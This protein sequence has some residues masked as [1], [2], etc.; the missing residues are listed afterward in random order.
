MPHNKH[1][2]KNTIISSYSIQ[3]TELNAYMPKT[4]QIT[5]YI[6]TSNYSIPT[7]ELNSYIPCNRHF[8]TNTITSDYSIQ[9]TGL[10]MATAVSLAQPFYLLTQLIKLHVLANYMPSSCVIKLHCLVKS[11]LS[12]NLLHKEHKVLSRVV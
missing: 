3:I 8:T 5:A 1:F 11:G 2:F 9:T 7:N 12:S 6:V 10:I 4:T